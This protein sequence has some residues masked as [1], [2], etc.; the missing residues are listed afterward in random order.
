MT[1]PTEHAQQ[2]RRRP[3][4][5]PRPAASAGAEKPAHRTPLDAIE[6]ALGVIPRRQLVHMPRWLGFLAV[7]SI[8]GMTPWVVYLGFTLPTK[9]ASH[10]YDVAWLG[11]DSALLLVL[12]LLGYN[13]LRRRPASGALA[14]VAAAM[15]VIDAWFDVTTSSGPDFALALLLACVG[16]I[17]LAI[18]CTWAAF[19]AE[20]RRARAYA[21]MRMRWQHAVDAARIAAAEGGEAA[22]RRLSPPTAV[23]RPQ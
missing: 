4:P 10:H 9:V 12:G 8:I 1:P 6:A 19:H 3:M 18:I 14:A 5:T 16:E 11:F 22:A 23:Q 20:Q 17:P 21:G 7:S 15:L 2:P 13:V